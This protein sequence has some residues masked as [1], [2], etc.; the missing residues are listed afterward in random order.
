MGGHF[1]FTNMLARLKPAMMTFEGYKDGALVST[2]SV[3]IVDQGEFLSVL[4]TQTFDTL[5][6]KDND[7]DGWAYM[8]NL[9]FIKF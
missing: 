2:V 3:D 7:S 5:V 4:M 1:S 6:I 8:D 9:L